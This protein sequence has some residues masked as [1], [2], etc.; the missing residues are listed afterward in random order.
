[1]ET[2]GGKRTQETAGYDEEKEKGFMV[3]GMCLC[4]YGYVYAHSM[5]GNGAIW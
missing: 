1:M 4:R 2:Q 3:R 5:Q